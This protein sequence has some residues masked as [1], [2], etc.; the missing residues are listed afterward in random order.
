M[1]ILSDFLDKKVY[2]RP[3]AILFSNNPGTILKDEDDNPY[4]VPDGNQGT[5]YIILT[6]DNRGPIDMS[7]NR[8]ETRKRMVNGRMRSYHIA[9]KL[10]IN[11]SWNTV[12]SRATSVAGVSITSD[13]GAG[14]VDIIDWYENHTGSFWVFLAYDKFTNF[15][16]TT[17]AKAH[18]QQYNQIIEVFFSDAN[19]SVQKRGAD[20]YDFWNVSLALEE[21]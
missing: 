17:N 3:Q 18:L 13:G 2:G 14:G 5:D 9:D 8:I 1:T 4:F 12:P 6:D 16:G 11:V 7:Y 20:T 15:E 10:K 19:Y 21:A